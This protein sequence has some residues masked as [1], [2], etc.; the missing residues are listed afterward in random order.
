[1]LT[2]R[3]SDSGLILQQFCDMLPASPNDNS[4]Y[5][6]IDLIRTISSFWKAGLSCH[7]RMM[8]WKWF[9]VILMSVAPI[10][11]MC[12]C[13]GFEL[14][15]SLWCQVHVS[16]SF[17]LTV[18]EEAVRQQIVIS[19]P[20]QIWWDSLCWYLLCTRSVAQNV[21]LGLFLNTDW[22]FV[23]GLSFD[24]YLFCFFYFR[25]YIC[26]SNLEAV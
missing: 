1:M 5:E 25:M 9:A 17:Q 22:G 18:N 16:S 19:E 4:R 26:V 12:F 24:Q 2:V 21:L 7:Q 8:K 11:L 23:L 10:G 20:W 15:L 6:A 13:E 3:S 14:H